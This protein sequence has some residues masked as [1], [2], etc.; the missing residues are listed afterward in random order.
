MAKITYGSTAPSVRAKH[1]LPG[2]E[3]PFNTPSSSGLATPADHP[4]TRAAS[5]EPNLRTIDIRAT[6]AAAIKA[7]DTNKA[8]ASAKKARKKRKRTVESG[9]S[10]AS[11]SDE[12]VDLDTADESELDE[13][14]GDDNGSKQ[15]ASKPTFRKTAYELERDANIAR[16]TVHLT[17]MGLMGP[18]S[19]LDFLKTST[20]EKARRSTKNRN[21]TEIGAS[22][23]G[24]ERRS[25][26]LSA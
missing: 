16:N 9:G 12:E 4:A 23:A 5:P 25:A 6:E 15:A 11:G 8:K 10:D 19:A 22:A 20:T 21:Q 14:G 1:A 3:K 18:G 7:K 26:R 2:T 13:G 17:K 24:R